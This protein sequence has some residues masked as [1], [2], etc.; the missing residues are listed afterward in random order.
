MRNVQ[1]SSHSKCECVYCITRI[2]KYRKKKVRGSKSLNVAFLINTLTMYI[3]H[4][5]ILQWT[6]SGT[7][8]K[9]IGYR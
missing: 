7:K 3:R 5:K 6:L 9:A 8:K 2:Q 4:V 1:S